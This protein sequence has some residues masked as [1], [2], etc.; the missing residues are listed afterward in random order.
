MKVRKSKISLRITIAVIGLLLLSDIAIGYTAFTMAKK[1]LLK[2][3]Q[4]NATNTAKCIAASISGADLAEIKAGDEADGG[5]DKYNS[6]LDELTLFLE[7]SGVEYCYTIGLNDA[8]VPVFLVDSD[9]DEPGLP[10]DDFGD[11]SEV[12]MNAFAGET[13][14]NDEPYT[15]EWGVH[16]SAYAPVMN[17]GDVAGLAVVDLDYGWVNEQSSG[18]AKS[19]III[20]V[21]VFLVG[22]AGLVVMSLLLSKGFNTLNNKV[23]DL[24]TG[25][26]DLTK[27]I[28]IATGDEFEVIADNMNNFIATI[29]E[30]VSNVADASTALRE[31]GA[32]LNS[33]I[34]GNVEAVIGMNESI[35]RISDNMQD[36]SSAGA[37]VSAELNSTVGNVER[38]LERIKEIE[39]LCSEENAVANETRKEAAIHKKKSIEEIEKIQQEMAVALEAAKNIEQVKEIAVKI[40]EIAG[41]TKMLSLNAQIEAA[42]AGEMGKGFAVV[43]TE[44]NRLST[45]ISEAVADMDVISREA[46]DS[47]DTLLR[48]SSDMSAFI[49]ENVV[50]D[51]DSFVE[52]GEKYGVSTETVKN[53]MIELKKSS[54]DIVSVIDAIDE[55]VASM[56]HAI[57]DSANEVSELARTSK[58]MSDNMSSI[59]EIS[60]MNE[61][62]SNDLKDT[63]GQYRY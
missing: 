63:V 36:C 31:S 50:G 40:N 15:D 1:S 54:E 35:N 46:V 48:C 45:A 32:D 34:E 9:P 42:R 58:D 22:V 37:E 39:K 18:I 59:K 3:I 57:A 7:N 23:I 16:L 47:V 30:L 20:C 44:V 33:T 38:F 55:S 28:E 56:A 26:G 19:I 4:N 24:S 6:I 51:Y 13:T 21:I 62:Q 61:V 41:Q 60:N 53:N 5:T 49:S 25:D 27:K 11:D 43:A 10:G 52:L 29:K 2:Q 17:E 14:V 8:G 12:V